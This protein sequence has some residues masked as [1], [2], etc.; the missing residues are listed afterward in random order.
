LTKTW[1]AETLY[2]QG[3]AKIQQ[4]QDDEEVWCCLVAVKSAAEAQMPFQESGK[5]F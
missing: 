3:K 5:H 4:I 1:S 2:K